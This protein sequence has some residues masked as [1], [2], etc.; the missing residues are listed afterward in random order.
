M[1]G[2][3]NHMQFKCRGYMKRSGRRPNGMDLKSTDRH[4]NRTLLV[5]N[6]SIVLEKE[7]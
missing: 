3:L 6:K 7:S 5:F 1:Q 2:M 4:L